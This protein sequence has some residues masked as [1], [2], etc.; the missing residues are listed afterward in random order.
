MMKVL[1]CCHSLALLNNSLVGDSLE[2][3]MFEE[4]QWH[5]EEVSHESNYS[6]HGI[7]IL[8]KESEE[9]VTKKQFQIPDYIPQHYGIIKHFDFSSEFQRMSSVCVDIENNTT[10]VTCKG[11]PEVIGD[12]CLP[13]SRKYKKKVYFFN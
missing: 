7:K 4:T 8:I 2:V 9:I 13:E 6:A 1:S 3:K 11:A 5:L 10:F 12:I